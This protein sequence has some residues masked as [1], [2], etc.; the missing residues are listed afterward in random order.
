MS[1]EQNKVKTAVAIAYDPK[2]VAP[3]VVASGKGKVAEKIIEKARESD[4]PVHE[5]SKLASTLSSL[6][7]GDA[8]PPELYEVVAEV[9]VFVDRMDKLK[10][11]MDLYNA[12][13][14]R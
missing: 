6:E 7:I 14:K 5:D 1:K 2:D 10:Q 11:K 8:I 9:L 13:A 4:V 3:T 12:G